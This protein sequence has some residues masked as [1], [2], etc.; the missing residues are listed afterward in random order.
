MKAS[1]GKIKLPIKCN[2]N[3]ELKIF[4]G[5]CWKCG[6]PIAKSFERKYR[7]PSCGFLTFH[8]DGKYY[9]EW[10]YL[11][12]DEIRVLCS[13][14]HRFVNY[15]EDTLG[16]KY[17]NI[18]KAVNDFPEFIKLNIAFSILIDSLNNASHIKYQDLSQA[19]FEY[20]RFLFEHGAYFYEALYN[21]NMCKLMYLKEEGAEKGQSSLPY[22]VQL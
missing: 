13:S 7:C 8:T 19:Y 1:K 4:D 21:S 16:K 18:E 9:D 11:D 17:D 15:L 22:A 2:F 20:A 10:E 3:R 6:L 5:K 14:A 12:L